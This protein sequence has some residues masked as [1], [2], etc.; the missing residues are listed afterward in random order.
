M[1]QVLNKTINYHEK[2]L[3]S[4]PAFDSKIF[5][6][7]AIIAL[8]SDWQWKSSSTQSII[9]KIKTNTLQRLRAGGF[10]LSISVENDCNIEKFMCK[11][12]ISSKAQTKT[13]QAFPMWETVAMHR[14]TQGLIGIPPVDTEH[15]LGFGN[16]I[17]LFDH[18]TPKTF[19]ITQSGSSN[20]LSGW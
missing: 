1:W 7:D 2:W 18:Y 19:C 10:Q 17:K 5:V 20:T 6:F 14:P 13:L 16:E 3:P 9:R 11:R 4:S 8:H 12:Q 15:F